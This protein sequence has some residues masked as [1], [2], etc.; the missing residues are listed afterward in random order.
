MANFYN[1]KS[2]IKLAQRTDLQELELLG[3][4]EWISEKTGLGRL[5]RPSGINTKKHEQEST[6]GRHSNVDICAQKHRRNRDS[7]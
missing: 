5:A 4:N 2:K 3:S 7:Y 6:V 1:S